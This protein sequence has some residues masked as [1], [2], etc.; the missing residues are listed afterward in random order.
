MRERVRDLERR[1]LRRG[2]PER[3]LEREGLRLRLRR[4]DDERINI[5]YQSK[6]ERRDDT[7]ITV[8]T[9]PP[10]RLPVVISTGATTASS[11]AVP[12]AIPVTIPVPSIAV[13]VPIPVTFPL[14]LVVHV[15]LVLHIDVHFL[16]LLSVRD[17]GE[18]RERKC[19]DCVRPGKTLMYHK[20]VAKSEFQIASVI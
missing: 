10:V 15:V 6:N 2:E 16:I 19:A 18:G 7:H 4:C 5:P 17:D 20:V 1:D 12:V 13:V 8:T 3:L 14:A 9:V 11:V